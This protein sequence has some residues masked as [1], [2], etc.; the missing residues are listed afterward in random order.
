[1]SWVWLALIAALV[2][3]IRLLAKNLM[4]RGRLGAA[5]AEIDTWRRVTLRIYV[6]RL[7]LVVADL[8]QL[9]TEG[10]K[11]AMAEGRVDQIMREIDEPGAKL[12][13]VVVRRQVVITS[14]G[15]VYLPFGGIAEY[16]PL[17]P[18]VV[19]VDGIP[20][21]PARELPKYDATLATW[22]PEGVS[23]E[24]RSSND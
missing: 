17:T 20:L 9:R 12:P 23:T 8:D 3:I 6:G 19:G 18:V 16:G 22:W 21:P 1:M 24:E 13:P 11:Q 7:G 15:E 4:I 5:E 2:W 10:M 14:D